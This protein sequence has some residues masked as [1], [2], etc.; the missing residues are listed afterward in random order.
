MDVDHIR[1]QLLE[2]GYAVVENVISDQECDKYKQQ[3]TRWASNL[4]GNG[5]WPV[6]VYKKSLIS[7]YRVGYLDPSWRV[8]LSAKAVFASIYGTE[9]LFSST[10]CVAIG[11]PPEDGRT[12]F[13]QPGDQWLHLDH[14]G[15]RIGFHVYQGAVYLE[16]AEED[17]W[18]LEVMEKSHSFHH[19]FLN[20][21]PNA[22]SKVKKT[23]YYA[24][25]E[26]A[27][28][29]YKD[30][31]CTIK[32]VPVPKGGMVLWDSRTVHANAKPQKG[33]QHPGRWRYLVL[34][35]MAPAK[36]ARPEDIERKKM[37]Y[38]NMQMTTHWP[39]AGVAIFPD[40]D[41]SSAYN[42]IEKLPAIAKTREARLLCGDL[43]YDF[44]DGK[45]NGPPE[46]QWIE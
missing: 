32:R 36:W 3:F 28:N 9:K 18:T 16:D 44:N 29:W 31:G 10:D 23:E 46:P 43:E 1:K 6:S 11:S 19:D 5:E 40:A 39:S 42:T 38:R 25:T 41:P 26:D 7:Q 22:T 24:L 45:P 34:V 37:A 2:K 14:S 17:D 20:V 35:C 12:E 21:F 27:I 4:F 33:R 15:R 8:R 30:H 13:H